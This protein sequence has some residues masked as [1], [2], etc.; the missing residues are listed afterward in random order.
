[1]YAA[2]IALKL[3]TEQTLL[4]AMKPANLTVVQ[5]N[6]DYAD[7]DAGGRT[8]LLLACEE[9]KS[10]TVEALLRNMHKW[11]I[12]VY[13]EAMLT[14][15]TGRL[16]NTSV[17]TA[18]MIAA[19]SGSLA[20]IQTLLE[21]NVDPS[22][23]PTD[24]GSTPLILAA[25]TGSY[26]VVKFL[27]DAGGVDANYGRGKDGVT[28]AYMA[29]QGGHADVLE[30]LVAY[31]AE[32]NT[33]TADTAE[34]P[35][36]VAAEFGNKLAVETLV[37]HGAEIEAVRTTDGI[38]A[39]HAACNEDTEA[40]TAVVAVL[41]A[42]GADP[43]HVRTNG[44]SALHGAILFGQFKV[45]KLLLAFGANPS[46]YRTVDGYTPMMV[47]AQTQRLDMMKLLAVYGASTA[48]Y[49][50][51]LTTHVM[52][53]GHL[54][55]I[56]SNLTFMMMPTLVDPMSF[57][58]TPHRND[59]Q[60]A[61]IST[62]SQIHGADNSND[63]S[64][65][66]PTQPVVAWTALQVAAATRLHKEGAQ[67]LKLG[68]IDP[69]A[70]HEIWKHHFFTGYDFGDRD[71]L[72]YYT[73]PNAA[74]EFA[75]F[76]SVIETARCEKPWDPDRVLWS[77]EGVTGVTPGTEPV[78]RETIAFIKRA[79]VG[80]RPTTHWL[81][82]AAFR[83][84]VHSALLV[85]E[86][87]RTKA[88]ASNAA[89]ASDSVVADDVDPVLLPAEIWEYILRFCLRSDWKVTRVPGSVVKIH[90]LKS[91]SDLNG[92]IGVVQSRKGDRWIVQPEVVFSRHI[93]S[94]IT[95]V[96]LKGE[97]LTTVPA[98]MVR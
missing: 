12:N 92:T 96:A 77:E 58:V 95:P 80:W 16:R 3:S 36:M 98:S 8:P 21:H 35:L 33:G 97:H 55:G 28:A 38:T 6:F 62:T 31:N 91:R 69:E 47:A 89:T 23:P 88:H 5:C 65:A 94:G 30:L 73:P 45:A 25:Y 2:P 71:E 70:D 72:E 14:S 81:H 41:L 27:L 84:A 83:T 79:T 17:R 82:H 43:N 63:G 85:S 49:G 13:H 59:E 4:G 76:L 1:M 15:G 87:L 90:G 67:A 29:A 54:G 37:K 66:P 32:V 56:P 10:A 42:N 78:C 57:S 64:R 18:A 44:N 74:T 68:L 22:I 61:F 51:K 20:I 40:N 46:L 26:D 19:Y 50:S 86:R 93:N 24:G 11:Q 48:T 34:T 53:S 75:G 9:R 52:N 39:L 7:L 60:V